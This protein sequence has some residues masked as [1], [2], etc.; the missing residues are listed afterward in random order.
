MPLL[1]QPQNITKVILKM[2]GKILISLFIKIDFVFLRGNSESKVVITTPY[3][4]V[5]G[6]EAI[7][8][9]SDIGKYFI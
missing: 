2:Q 4:D 9:T 5:T 3:S 6:F 8:Q 1:Y 7:H